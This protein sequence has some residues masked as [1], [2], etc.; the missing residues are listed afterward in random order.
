MLNVHTK[1]LA[2]DHI[3]RYSFQNIHTAL[4]HTPAH[5]HFIC[6][7]FHNS[8]SKIFFLIQSIELMI[9]TI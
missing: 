5:F 4:I 1:P 2:H 8:D 3:Y 7:V 9:L 6:I